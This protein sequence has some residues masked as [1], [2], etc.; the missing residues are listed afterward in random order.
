MLTSNSLQWSLLGHQLCQYGM[1][2]WEDITELSCHESFKPSNC[3]IVEPIHSIPLKPKPAIGYDPETVPA[4]SHSQ[5]YTLKN[6][7][8]I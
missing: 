1:T 8:Q 7:L 3:L 6:V 4:A 5:I 2:D